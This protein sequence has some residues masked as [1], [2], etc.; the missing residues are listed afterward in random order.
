M[1]RRVL[2]AFFLSFLVLYAYQALFVP[3]QDPSAGDLAGPAA[4][5]S[6]SAAAGP[7]ALDSG[8]AT[9]RDRDATEAGAASQLQ[10][11]PEAEVAADPV[12]ASPTV[13]ADTARDIVVDMPAFTAV[14]ANRGAELVSWKLKNYFN[15]GTDTPVDLVPRELP[16][17]EP[18]PFAL[19]FADTALTARA[20]E[21]LYRATRDGFTNITGPLD[22]AEG[23][24]TLVFDY[25]E[26]AG[27]RV[28]KQFHF[29]P[30]HPFVV[31]VTIDA[32]LNGQPQA[33][34]IRWGPALGGVESSS[35]GFAYRVGPRGVLFGGVR[36]LDGRVEEGVERSDGDAIHA[37]FLQ[38]VGIDN[39]YF[40]AAALPGG[41][42]TAVSYRAVPQPPLA[43]GGD[44]R[45]LMAFDLAFPDDDVNEM[46]F[47]LGPKDFEILEAA[48]ATMVRS[49]EFGWFGWLVVPLH[50]SLTW[51][52]DYVGNWGWSI[53]ILTFLINIVI[54]PL[55]HKSVMSMR[56]MQ[57]VQ[58]EMKAIQERY[59]HL[60]TTDP[61]KQKMN[62]EVMALY[63][64][65]GVNPASGCLP[66]LLTMPV[67]FAFYRLLS[68]SIEIRGEPFV[69][70][71]TD[72]A[73]RD[74]LYILPAFMGASMVVQQRMT[75]T[76]A[77]PMQQKIMMFMP[78]MF[79]VMMAFA[80]S[81][82]VLYWMTS[83]VLGI[84]QQVATNR[85][86]GPPKV[87]TVRP[88]AESR[89]KK[90]GGAKKAK[91]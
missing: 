69:G 12:A 89:A 34:A 18:A 71:I 80:P 28:S 9:A 15:E 65:K 75:P 43:D 91:A 32:T 47:F 52:H 76:P 38:F 26:A 19:A 55:K 81:G 4:A 7:A 51:V 62:Q 66:M 22:V 39:H 67:L 82:L 54:F 79:T 13:S 87:R 42:E 23:A 45:S 74:P 70:W 25:E 44:V 57:E 46:P 10:E 11:T 17:E 72:L 59:K 33:P 2:L 85:I 56:K 36:Q 1:E 77:D 3:S 48:H 35:S 90:I 24:T 49:I 31:T 78:I 40:I 20:A 27:L 8:R 63:R 37:G 21:A 68:M 83:N 41:V 61:D 50:R 14:F 6:G 88:A 30:A 58:P 60:K 86:I 84:G 5:A 16:Q 29:D 53:I 73:V 64:D